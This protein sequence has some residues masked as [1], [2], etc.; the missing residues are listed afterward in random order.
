MEWL[1]DWMRQRLADNSRRP[2]T[3]P[4]DEAPA[5][6]L[7]GSIGYDTAITATGDI[8]VSEYELD[9]PAGSEPRWRLAGPKE[10]IGYLVIAARR[11]PE[12]ARMLPSR[13]IDQPDCASCD[14]T[15]AWT[16]RAPDGTAM[17]PA[18]GMICHE[19]AG[20]G[21]GAG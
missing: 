2:V 19:C 7:H 18:P 14:G 12:F 16:L 8:W 21:W 20:L 3:L 15:G 9:E 10:R 13:P 17:V 5:V 11:D 6:Y 4:L 1:A